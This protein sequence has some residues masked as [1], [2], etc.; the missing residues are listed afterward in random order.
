M[1]IIKS[2]I[3]SLKILITKPELPIDDRLI[4]VKFKNALLILGLT[5]K[6]LMNTLNHIF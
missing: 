3:P 6:D 4:C 1:I 2:I 5:K